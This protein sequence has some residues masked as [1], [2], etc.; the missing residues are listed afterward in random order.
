MR[1]LHFSPSVSEKLYT[2]GKAPLKASCVVVRPR[3][4]VFCAFTYMSIAIHTFITLA[5]ISLIS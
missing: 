4:R 5:L 3:R 2:I 1:R